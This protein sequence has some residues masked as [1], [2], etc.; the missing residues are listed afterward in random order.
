MPSVGGYQITAV[1]NGATT[2]QSYAYDSGG[3][4]KSIARDGVTLNLGYNSADQVT[5]VTNGTRWVTYVHDA[6]GRRT[7]ST[8]SD[9][10]VRRTLVAGTP[11][12]DLESAQLIA[13]ANGVVQQGYIYVGESPLL[14]FTSNGTAGYY[15]EDGYGSVI[16]LAPTDS[17][18]ATNTT[19]LFYDGFGNSRATNGP[20]PIV[21]TGAEGDFRFHGAWL[22]EAGLT[23]T[24][25]F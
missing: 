10:T 18:S 3:R 12:T 14:R 16:A 22:E 13:D 2:A 15:L 7:I 6:V 9:G 20:A 25:D 19:C 23:H 4:I 11:G 5:A 1:M 24:K 21:P 8:N 17:P